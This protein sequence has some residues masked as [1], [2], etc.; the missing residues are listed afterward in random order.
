MFTRK[1][2]LIVLGLALGFTSCPA[3]RQYE[4]TGTLNAPIGTDVKDTSVVACNIQDCTVLSHAKADVITIGVSGLTAQW[5]IGLS[6]PGKYQMFAVN[7]VQGL[8]GIYKNPANG[9][10]IVEAQD[11]FSPVKNIDISLQK[12][13]VSAQASE[14]FSNA[15]PKLSEH[16]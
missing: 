10:S 9:S 2:L 8:I 11:S 5:R 1:L 13:T 4:L 3:P 12:I 14:M 6:N 15:F 16:Q 7:T